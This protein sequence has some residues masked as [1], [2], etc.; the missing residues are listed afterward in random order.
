MSYLLRMEIHPVVMG[1]AMANMV[2]MAMEATV[3]S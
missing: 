3:V 2:L 1:T